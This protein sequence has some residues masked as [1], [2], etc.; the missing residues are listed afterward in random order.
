MTLLIHCCICFPKTENRKSFI[1]GYQSLRQLPDEYQ[2]ILE[3]FFLG[4][5]VNNFAF[6]APQPNE[7]DYLLE[8]VPYVSESFCSKYL[9]GEAFLFEL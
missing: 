2:S 9:K 7:H 6:L 1:S 8:T 5:M 4:A 3:A